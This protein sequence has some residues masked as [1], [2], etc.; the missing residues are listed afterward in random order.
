MPPDENPPEIVL[1]SLRQAQSSTAGAT[2]AVAVDERGISRPSASTSP[3]ASLCGAGVSAT[4]RDSTESLYSALCV[5]AFTGTDN[6]GATAKGV[7]ADQIVIGVQVSSSSEVPEGPLARDFS[8]TDTDDAHD[9]KVW[10]TYFNDRFVFYNRYLQFYVV[11]ASTTDEDL[12]RAAVEAANDKIF[13]YIPSGL[14]ISGAAAAGRRS[15]ARPSRSFPGRTRVD[16]YHSSR[17]YAYSFDIDSWQMRALGPELACKH[18][19]GEPPGSLNNK[20]DLTFDYDAPR[21]FGLV[22]YQDSVRTGARELF[23][24][25]FSRLCGGVFKE[26]A[27]YN[28]NDNQAAIGDTVAKMRRAG[29]TT[30]MLGV[31]PLTPAVLTNAAARLQYFPEWIGVVGTESNSSGRYLQDD[32]AN[33]VVSIAQIEI[34]RS[35]ADKDWYRAYKEID[36]N[37]DPSSR[38]FRELQQLSGGIQGAGP[39]LTPETFW[40]G[41]TKQ[42]CRA[43]VPEWSI[44][45]CYRKADPT[46][47][48]HYLGDY[49]YADYVALQWFDNGGKD[50]NS[51]VPGAWCY[52]YN[53][54]RFEYTTLPTDPLPFRDPTQCIFTP[55]KGVQG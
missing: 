45:G 3:A 34:P 22:L 29:V 51:S 10:Q 9:L 15:E 33:N 44:G 54:R 50:P 39:G 26:V 48:L 47:D 4:L 19:W 25:N 12:A 6:G 21:A 31:D 20:M 49:S 35:S 1:Q 46:S 11:K 17:P 18:W 14:E 43:P 41:L 16:F 28:L 53:G 36:P 40:D 30:I 7:T 8:P 5:P 52:M 38:Y 55:D 2:A 32:Q 24:N 37:G 27:E 42:P 13:A 23:S